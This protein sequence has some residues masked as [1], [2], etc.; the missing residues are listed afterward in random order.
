MEREKVKRRI[1]IGT[2][3]AALILTILVFSLGI[4]VGM[5]IDEQAQGEVERGISSLEDKL[6]FSRILMLAQ[7][8]I[9]E[10][11]PIYSENLE[12]VAAEREL[13]GDRLEYLEEVRGVYDAQLKES[14][15]YLEL[16]NYLLLRKMQDQCGGSQV[17]ILFFYGEGEGSLEQGAVLD[18]LRAKN[19][20]VKV[21][22]FDGEMD[23]SAV[24]AL[25][26]SYGVHS[27][28][29]LVIDGQTVSGLQSLV[30]IEG[31]ISGN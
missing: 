30:E 25:I 24:E 2:Y 20:N 15:F 9:G 11:C 21:F 16:E 8:E 27:Y 3:L 4:Y 13:I 31:I 6:Y 14:Y 23:S 12:A 5:I 28:P 10:F 18:S 1:S 26:E 22:S 7:E 19:G 17:L 29:S